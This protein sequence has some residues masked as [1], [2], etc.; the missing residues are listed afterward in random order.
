MK[1][2]FSE[3]LTRNIQNIFTLEFAKKN[4]NY[5]GSSQDYE[6]VTFFQNILNYYNPF[7]VFMELDGYKFK[8][9]LRDIRDTYSIPYTID[10]EM[11][12][13]AYTELME[14]IAKERSDYVSIYLEL[15]SD[16]NIVLLSEP[17]VY[18][19]KETIDV[20][21]FFTSINVNQIT[22]NSL[23]ES[24]IHPLIKQN[25]EQMEALKNSLYHKYSCLIGGAGTGKSFVTAELINQLL[26]NKRDIVVLAPTHKAR[27]ALQDK[28][29]E[30]CLPVKVRTI[31][32]FAYSKKKE[33]ID[34]III[35]E[36][37]MIPTALLSKLTTRLKE[38][39]TIF[40]GD[41][42]QL[43]P[44]EYG[45]PFET[46]QEI[47]PKVELKKNNRSESPDIVKLGRW[48]LGTEEKPQYTPN[49]TQVQELKQAYELKPD[50][51]I[52]FLN[53]TVDEI[54][55]HFRLK[56]TNRSISQK[57]AIGERIFAENNKAG[58]YYNGQ[59]FIIESYKSIRNEK[60]GKKIQVYNAKELE[61]SFTYA[62]A[63]T[64]HKSQGSEW[65]TV[66]WIP[67]HSEYT[68]SQGNIQNLT[69]TQNL[70]YVA[71]TRAKRKL[72]IVGDKMKEKYEPQK[73]WIRL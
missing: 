17:C 22:S 24:Q 42:N 58:R 63:L 6:P 23:H 67:T 16:S 2:D 31:H 69:D 72:I 8:R 10:Q 3:A 43:E 19:T 26:L 57:F 47:L 48:I 39:Q 60:T 15:G 49:I 35:D 46:L 1:K 64:V 44:I 53:E 18:T 7:Y 13:K 27:E 54:N 65:N 28:L 52:S 38:T 29:D 20:K 66:A 21:R 9:A 56:T 14:E 30:R 51:Y 33:N 68:D 71:V 12:A 36:S 62:Y 59:I 34:T 37:G 41:K 5:T 4:Y 50:V 70:A 55:E 73:G 32:S 61:E 45:R 11:Q 40:V 25:E